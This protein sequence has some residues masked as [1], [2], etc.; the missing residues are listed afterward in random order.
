MQVEYASVGALAD[1]CNGQCMSEKQARAL[2][3]QLLEGL[4]YCHSKG[5]FHRD[6]RTEHILLSGRWAICAFCNMQILYMKG[7]AF[8]DVRVA[9]GPR[10][11]IFS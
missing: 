4:A 3:S 1:R 10:R 7:H 6:L 11:C 2:F 9:H 5:V 8:Y